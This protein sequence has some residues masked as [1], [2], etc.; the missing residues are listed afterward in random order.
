MVGIGCCEGWV[1]EVV[2]GLDD[3]GDIRSGSEG[4]DE[5]VVGPWD[6]DVVM[7]ELPV[8]FYVD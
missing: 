7:S 6:G 2:V 8:V 3:E 4:V 1:I 5:A